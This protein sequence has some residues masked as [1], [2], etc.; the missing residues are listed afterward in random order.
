VGICKWQL[1]LVFIYAPFRSNVFRL[2]GVRQVFVPIFSSLLIELLIR[3]CAWLRFELF[4]I[5]LVR[6]FCVVEF[7]VDIVV[8]DIVAV[9]IVVADIVAAD[10]FAKNNH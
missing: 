2:P 9:D 8:A 5:I 1:F 7:V 4:H 10:L 6:L 3:S